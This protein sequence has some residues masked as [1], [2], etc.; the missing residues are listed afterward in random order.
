MP[1]ATSRPWLAAAAVFAVLI[2]TLWFSASRTSHEH[3]L[4]ALPTMTPEATPTPDVTPT[5]LST[6][7]PTT[8]VEFGASG[9]PAPPADP[10]LLA[11]QLSW[12][13]ALIDDPATAPADLDLA[14][15]VQQVAYRRLGSTPAWDEAVAAQLPPELATRALANAA[16][17][18]SFKGLIPEPPTN[19]PPWEIIEPESADALLGY[20]QEAE[21]TFGIP[22]QYLAA[23]NLIETGMGRIR[24]LSTA[25]ARGPMQFIAPTW[26]T[27]GRGGDIDDPHDSIMAAGRYLAY[28]AAN[29]GGPVAPG[30][31]A[32]LDALWHYN[33]HDAYVNGVEA[34]ARIMIDDPR[35]FYGY[36]QWEIYYWSSEGDI[37][38]PVGW[39]NDGNETAAEYVAA[40]PQ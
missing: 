9:A 26:E 39:K 11:A 36:H 13:Y 1:P 2:A 31:A 20:C 22:W 27:F 14:G 16:A 28:E 38:L 6:P 8:V 10:K 35:A 30:S 7:T 29:A 21:A 12:S 23:I 15:H 33:N 17:R 37:W 18:R 32:L 3:D 24:G 25:G 4:E 34:Y 19:M 40:H 5:P